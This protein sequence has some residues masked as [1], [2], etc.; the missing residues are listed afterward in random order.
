MTYKPI[1]NKTLDVLKSYIRKIRP[2]FF[3][4]KSFQDKRYLYHLLQGFIVKPKSRRFIARIEASF[5]KSKKKFSNYA[6]LISENSFAENLINIDTNLVSNI[7]SSI[8]NFK[9]HDLESPNIEFMINEKP[10]DCNLAYYHTKD[11]YKIKEVLEIA[12]NDKLIATFNNLYGCDPIIDYIGAWWSFPNNSNH[13]TQKW[14]RDMDSL[15]ILKFFV[16]LTDVDL[17][18]GPHKIII[19]SHREKFSAGFGSYHQDKDVK[20]LIKKNGYKVFIG[21]AGTNFMEDVFAVH[22]GEMPKKNPRLA[23]EVLYSRIQ[24]PLSPK[25]PFIDAKNSEFFDI[26]IKNKDLF[27]NIVNF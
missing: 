2:I 27:K 1:M 12:T 16:Y 9:C 24:S 17:D 26:F 21:P 3:I 14:H 23:L 20:S 10:I 19:G 8:E 6:L 11:L 4:L 18:S 15:N 5:F 25:K 13:G 22:K 7:K